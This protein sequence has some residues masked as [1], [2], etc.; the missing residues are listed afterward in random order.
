MKLCYA[1]RIS[2]AA[3]L[4]AAVAA[5]ALPACA[6]DTRFVPPGTWEEG[7]INPPPCLL[8]Q[9]AWAAM[10]LSGST[11][12]EECPA[13]MHELWLKD[14]GHWRD[15]RRIRIGYDG[16][17]YALPAL[18]WTQSSFIQPQTMIHDRYLYDPAS[19]AYTVDRYAMVG[20]RCVKDARN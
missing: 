5:T 14:I 7:M 1:G 9:S 10:Y 6:Q 3:V 2:L 17:R 13:N 15:E 12:P 8:L 19:G 4:L 18:E 20:F 16:A 11:V